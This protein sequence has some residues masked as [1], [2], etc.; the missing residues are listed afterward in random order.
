MQEPA[1]SP[2]ASLWPRGGGGGGR[3]HG[4]GKLPCSELKG[5]R[6]S[7]GVSSHLAPGM[8]GRAAG[9]EAGGLCPPWSRGSVTARRCSHGHPGHA[10]GGLVPPPGF[11]RPSPQQV[12]GP[13][14]NPPTVGAGLPPLL[15][16]AVTQAIITSSLFPPPGAPHLLR[17]GGGTTPAPC[18]PPPPVSGLE[19]QTP[20]CRPQP[21]HS[22][23]ND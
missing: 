6:S 13:W 7:R 20:G 9:D 12:R 14:T 3:P 4:S 16:P 10:Q 5:V 8:S 23:L 2:G 18:H 21:G 11:C 15:A 22:Q 1:A 17:H 19:S